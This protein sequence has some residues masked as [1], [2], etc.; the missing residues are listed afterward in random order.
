MRRLSLDEREFIQELLNSD[1]YPVLNSLID[2][3]CDNI[4]KKVLSYDLN[5]GPEGL[6]IA[7]ARSEG[8]RILQREL[9]ALGQQLKQKGDKASLK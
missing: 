2:E 8:S 3:L 5:Q 6:V 7:K 9:L 4:D 1:G